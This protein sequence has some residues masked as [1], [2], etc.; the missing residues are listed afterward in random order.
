MGKNRVAGIVAEYNP[1][2]NGH[3]HQIAATRA[4][5]ATHLVAVMSGNF[6]QRGGPAC[7][8]K[9]LRANAAIAG[10]VDL[11]LELPLPYAMATAERFAFG[12]V[13]TLDALGGIDLL[14][15]G[16]ESAELPLLQKAAEAVASSY[17]YEYTAHLLETGITYAAARRQAVERLY[18]EAVAAVLDTPNDTLAVEYLRQITLS[19]S[20]MTPL[21]VRRIGTAHDSGESKGA[22]ASASHL[23]HLLSLD[24][25]AALN[26]YQPEAV[27]QIYHTGAA[28]GLFP[29][30]PETLTLPL[31]SRL[32]GMPEEAFAAL[33]DLS[34]GLHHRLYEAARQAV[35]LDGL[36]AAVKTKR[37]PLSRIRRLVW[38]A[39]LG[40][41]GDLM[42]LSPPYLRPLA[43]NKRGLEL[44]S[45]A[46]QTARLSL[47]T[48]LKKL[49]EMGGDCA[50]FAHLEAAAT[51]QYA[52]ALPVISPC[53][54]D[55][56]ARISVR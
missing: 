41:P 20:R 22:F 50:R 21:V 55:Y 13:R 1:F 46:K 53:G 4:A 24:G 45:A 16:S 10:G 14:S 30:Q 5:G 12:A 33:P 40:V 43:F 29:C 7:A 48:S 54:G 17:C 34:E 35:G 38:N 32:R 26:L 52:L 2:H 51:D 27:H 8:P 19:G 39:F 9:Q 31:L 44:L 56:T 6:V 3:A 28:G 25:L 42:Q 47:S 49:E 11:V 36:Y 15:F 23:R 37:Y 18:G